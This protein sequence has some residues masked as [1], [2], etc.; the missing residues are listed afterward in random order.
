MVTGS[1]A[2]SPR[3]YELRIKA[4]KR[5]RQTRILGAK[6]NAKAM[7]RLLS[8][9]KVQPG[10]LSTIFKAGKINCVRDTHRI[11]GDLESKRSIPVQNSI[12]Q[13]FFSLSVPLARSPQHTL[14]QANLDKHM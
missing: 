11:K 7:S 9:S 2:T 12:V 3:R 5:V 4:V 6:M 10:R 1:G 8:L 13:T 14:S